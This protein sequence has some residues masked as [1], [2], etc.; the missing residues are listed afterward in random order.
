M[1]VD[2]GSLLLDLGRVVD[3]LA[4]AVVRVV[5]VLGVDTRL[6]GHVRAVLG[7]ALLAINVEEAV[8]GPLRLVLLLGNSERVPLTHAARNGQLISSLS[9]DSNRLESR[10]LVASLG[11]A[12]L[13]SISETSK[14]SSSNNWVDKSS[15]QHS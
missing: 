3:K 2:R 15:E 14:K 6:L 8:S 9:V 7:R 11:T 5:D 4:E 1:K 10:S 13:G 12:A